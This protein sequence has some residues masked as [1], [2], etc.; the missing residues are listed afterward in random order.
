MQTLQLVI[1][2]VISTNN[3][4]DHIVK[5]PILTFNSAGSQVLTL[6]EIMKIFVEEMCHQALK[7]LVFR[8]MKITEQ[9]SLPKRSVEQAGVLKWVKYQVRAT[10]KSKIITK[11]KESMIELK[12]KAKLIEIMKIQINKKLQMTKI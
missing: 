1:H 7:A 12:E 8:Q 11:T 2:R 6:T 4:I 3:L 9:A 10:D 5:M